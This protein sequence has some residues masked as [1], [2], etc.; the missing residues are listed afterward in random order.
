[1]N[2]DGTTTTTRVPDINGTEIPDVV[3]EGKEGD[4]YTTEEAKN[5]NEKYELVAEKLPAN[6]TGTIEKYNEEK[7][8]EV[9]YYYRLKP[10]KV[11]INYL[12]KDSN[13]V[14]STQER[15]IGYVDDSYNTNTDHRKEKIEKDGKMYTLVEDS[16]NTEGTMTVADTVVTYYYL[17]NTKATVRYVAR[18]SDTHEIVKDL[19]EPYTQEGLV[20]D[21]FVTNEKA[22]DRI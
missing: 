12:E 4:S 18:D 17:Q 13:Q 10:A 16:G 5:I 20:G 21:K 8:Q 6:A 3:I 1:M 2:T 14:L 9:I 11:I 19:E 15:I 22:F 7:P